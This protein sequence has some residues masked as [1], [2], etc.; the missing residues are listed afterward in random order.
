MKFCVKLAILAAGLLGLAGCASSV[1]EHG[2]TFQ[3]AVVT[4][5]TS[6]KITGD[7]S[8]MGAAIDG[9]TML[10]ATSGANYANASFTI[11][12]SKPCLFNMIALDQGFFE[13]HFPR[14]VAIYTSMDG[15]NWSF[16]YAAPGTRRVTVMTWATPVLARYV[17][18]VAA[19][20]GEKPW[21]VA[22]VYIQ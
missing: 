13:D 12:L 11:D 10:P 15:K 9:N 7:L 22:E 5:N 20:P 19:M 18:V 3:A 1:Y 4:P 14:R 6:W 21:A 17:K 2:P 16:I 8:N